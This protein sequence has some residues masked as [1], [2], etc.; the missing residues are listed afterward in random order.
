MEGL[1]EEDMKNMSPEQIAELQKKNCIF[2][3]IIS[4]EVPSK[5]VYEDPDFIGILDINPGVE[6]HVLVL[7]K[8]HF[9]VMP[10]MPPE[11]AG[12]FGVACKEVSQRIL[13][14]FNVQGTS[15][16][17]GNGFVAG[18]KAPHFM[19]HVIPR[20]EGDGVS[21][22]P[23][24]EDVSEESYVAV[25]KK[26]LSGLGQPAQPVANTVAGREE[27]KENEEE[28]E[29]KEER[30]QGPAKKEEESEGEEVKSGKGS[31]PDLDAIS[32]MFD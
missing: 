13:K 8:K 14:A 10:Q 20:K 24:L 16:F 26:L 30:K 5:K 21:L 17:M 3:K 23:V 6:G 1:T 4:G 9:Q 32:R 2:C 28:D 12:K 19:G 25:K 31:G 7:P 29:N 11:L 22:N 18:Q 15:I 27:K